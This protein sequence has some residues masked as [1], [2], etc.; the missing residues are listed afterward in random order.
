MTKDDL[1]SDE[2]VSDDSSGEGEASQGSMSVD[3]AVS[4]GD[5]DARMTKKRQNKIMRAASVAVR[6]MA[7]KGDAM[8]KAMSGNYNTSSC[9]E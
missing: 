3:G 4:K 2:T 1:H 5:G 7:D 6:M 9:F 8:M